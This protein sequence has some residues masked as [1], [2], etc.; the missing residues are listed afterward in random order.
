MPRHA[1]VATVIEKN[2]IAGDFAFVALLEVQI[3]DPQNGSL[4]ETLR[5][6][7]NEEEITYEGESW[8]PANFDLSFGQSAKDAPRVRLS[9]RDYT[10]AIMSRIEAENGGLG[11]E[12]RVLIVNAGDLSQPTEIDE[13]FF[14]LGVTSKNFTVEFTLGARNPLNARFPRRLQMRDRCAWRYKGDECGYSGPLTSCDY[15]LNGPNGCRAHAN[16]TRFGGFPGLR[17]RNFG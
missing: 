10:G 8:Q 13:T 6:A 4:I 5:Y 14:V 17:P 3:R 11:F 1:S 2:K 7:R 16:E 9:V 12:L 15:S